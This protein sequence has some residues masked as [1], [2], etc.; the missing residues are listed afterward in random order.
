MRKQ[1]SRIV[2]IIEEVQVVEV[3]VRDQDGDP[4]ETYYTVR[5]ERF[6]TLKTAMEAARRDS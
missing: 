1:T 2:T 3:T 4:V 5:G 6:E